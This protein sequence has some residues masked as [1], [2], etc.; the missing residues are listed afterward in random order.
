MHQHPTK[1]HRK[2]EANC[3]ESACALVS[4]PYSGQMIVLLEL[5]AK[6]WSSVR[7]M[8][9]SPHPGPCAKPLPCRKPKPAKCVMVSGTTR[10]HNAQGRA[11]H[12]VSFIITKFAAHII[13]GRLAI[14]KAIHVSHKI[15]IKFFSHSHLCMSQFDRTPLLLV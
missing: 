9:A 5:T 3:P 10:P 6:T 2:V 1:K 7:K 11:C 8:C 15:S 14:T 12:L 4:T 13:N